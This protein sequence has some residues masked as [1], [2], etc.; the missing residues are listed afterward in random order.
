MKEYLV[1]QLDF[2]GKWTTYDESGI[3]DTYINAM[4]C[5]TLTK[6]LNKMAEDEWE[7]HSQL[8]RSGTIIFVRDKK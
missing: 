7:Y 6:A 5:E 4:T 2:G 1:M 3:S 8:E